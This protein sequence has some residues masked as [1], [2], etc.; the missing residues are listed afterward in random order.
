M[1]PQE[2]SLFAV[3]WIR[4]ILVFYRASRRK[5]SLTEGLFFFFLLNVE[6]L[7]Y[8][9]ERKN[10][11]H[12]CFHYLELKIDWLWGLQACLMKEDRFPL[13]QCSKLVQIYFC[14]EFSDSDDQMAMNC[15]LNYKRS[16][17]SCCSHFGMLFRRP[18][19]YSW[20]IQVADSSGGGGYQSQTDYTVCHD[21]S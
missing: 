10:L 8:T 19:G 21:A 11:L 3:S 12:M 6:I 2:T 1:N 20:Q 18:A 14:R 13:S 16:E 15:E 9:L 7:F 5:I 17:T 4:V